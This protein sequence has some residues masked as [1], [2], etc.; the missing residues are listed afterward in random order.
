MKRLIFILIMVIFLMTLYA[1]DFTE[2]YFKFSL[3]SQKEMEK[4]GSIVSIDNVKN[5]EV[6]AYANDDTFAKFKT[7]GYSYEIL[8]HPNTQLNNPKMATDTAS[9]RDWDSYPTYE[10]Y[11]DFMYEFETNHPDICQVTNLGQSVEGRDILVAKISDNVDQEEAEPE[12]FYTGQMHGDELATFMTM[13][14][15]IDY[16]TENYGSDAQ[17]N[18]LVNNTE[19]FINPLAN[20]DGTYHGG[21]HTVQGAIRANANGVD[22]N[23]NFPDPEDGEHPDGNSHQPETLVMIDFAE[24]HNFVAS[25]NLHGGAEVVN[26]PWDTWP[27]LHADDNWWQFVSSEYADTAQ[28][29]S[30]ADYMDGFNDG[31]TNGYQW[32]TTNGNRQDHMNYFHHCREFTLEIS[33][34]K[35]LPANELLDHWDYNKESLLL[36][37]EQVHYGFKGTVKNS[38]NEPLEAEI[39]IPDHDNNESMV[40]TDSDFGDFYRPIFEGTYDIEISAYGYITQTLNNVTIS[41]YSAVVEDIVLEQAENIDISGTVIDSDTDEPIEGA[42]VELLDTPL[43]PATTDASGNYSINNVLEG[44]YTFQVWAEGYAAIMEDHMINS[45]NTVFNFELMVSEAESFESGSFTGGWDFYGNA[46][47]TITD[48]VAYDGLHAA[49]SGDINDNQTS[50]L[51]FEANVNADGQIVF[52][53]KVSSEEAYDFMRFY[54]D[55]NEMDSWSGEDDWSEES[56]PVEAGTRTF[57]WVY[58]K[59]GSVSEGDDCGWIDYVTFPPLGDPAELAVNPQSFEIEM[60]QNETYTEILELTNTGG[61]V[62]DFNLSIGSSDKSKDRDLT[63]STVECSHTEFQPGEDYTLTFTVSCVSSDNEWIKDV[64]IE[65]PEGVNVVS[66]TDLES[67]IPSDGATGDGATVHWSGSGYLS[68]GEVATADVEIS[69]S[70]GFVSDMILPW[71]IHGDEWGNPPHEITGEMMLENTGNPITWISLTPTSGEVNS[72]ETFE[73][74]VNFD[75]ADLP[76]G[77]Y[78]CNIIISDNREETYIPVSLEVGEGSSTGDVVTL[79]TALTGNYPNPFNPETSIA[80]SIGNETNTELNI[81]NLKGQK[82][83]TLIDRK[84]KTGEYKIEWD[85]SD[86]EGKK[87]VSGIYFYQLKTDKYSQI[88]KMILLK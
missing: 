63:G 22:L 14:H 66:S 7:L 86:A 82:V 18:N 58:E 88:N 21:N 49:Q 62:L 84:L 5:G 2:Y 81:F 25:A 57:R 80:F 67:D 3:K 52:Y 39:L 72:G 46:D 37:M 48:A 77:N 76:E 24:T 17:V 1:K 83:I 59:D 27:Q 74:E 45:E 53:K 38:D 11:I 75:S 65:F 69:V 85:G 64:W 9:M 42:I 6:Y 79:E 33:N 26:Y 78:S 15:L 87:V 31:I 16:L 10:T 12:F 20:P 73:V 4:I 34:V 60:G 44:T 70:S 30:S 35:M 61:G 54:I 29:H 43:E 13:L 19:I 36:Y 23:R 71:I 40:Y 28:E 8:P 47:W 50:E 68:D 32:Y 41:N 51:A 56:Y 55:D